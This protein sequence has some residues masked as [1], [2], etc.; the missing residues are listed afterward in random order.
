VGPGLL[1]G[2]RRGYFKQLFVVML[3]AQHLLA[4]YMQNWRYWRQIQTFLL[5]NPGI[6]LRGFP[7]AGYK[8]PLAGRLCH[9]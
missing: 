2:A 1:E 9:N 3:R 7:L 4:R 6:Q 8:G 5:L